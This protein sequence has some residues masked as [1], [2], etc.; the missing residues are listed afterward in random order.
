MILALLPL[1]A[2]ATPPVP[3][4]FVA[5]DDPDLRCMVAV[6]FVLGAA[7]EKGA[8]AETI[9]GMTAVFMYFLGKVDA[10]YPGEDLA[11]VFNQVV[12][13]REYERQLPADLTRCGGEAEARGAALKQLGQELKGSVPLAPSSAG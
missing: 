11:K 6:S 5:V 2:A 8:D 10:R 1:L 3:H 12:G 4:P 7:S 9:G 13:R